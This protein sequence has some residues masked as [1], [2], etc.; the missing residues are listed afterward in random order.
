MKFDLNSLTRLNKI[1]FVLTLSYLEKFPAPH[2]SLAVFEHAAT[3]S[4]AAVSRTIQS[5]SQGL[6]S[7]T[8]VDTAGEYPASAFDVSFFTSFPRTV[9]LLLLNRVRVNRRLCSAFS[10]V[11]TE[12][13]TRSILSAVR[14]LALRS[15]SR[16]SGQMGSCKLSSADMARTSFPLRYVVDYLPTESCL[17]DL[18]CF[19]GQSDLRDPDYCNSHRGLCIP[20]LRTV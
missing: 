4:A 9:S 1:R 16:A 20:S 17:A 14:S 6:D 15:L 3:E 10:M 5:A 8:I 12:I 2:N 18:V 13:Q 7:V 11:D 19:F